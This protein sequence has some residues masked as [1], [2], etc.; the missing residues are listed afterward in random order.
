MK[1]LIKIGLS[2]SRAVFILLGALYLA[3]YLQVSV[4][5]FLILTS[6]IQMLV[7]SGYTIGTLGL[8]GG[9][10]GAHFLVAGKYSYEMGNLETIG[11][12]R[13]FYLTTYLIQ[14][15]LVQLISCLVGLLCFQILYIFITSDSVSFSQLA[16]VHLKTI[17]TVLPLQVI[18]C[19][20]GLWYQSRSEPFLLI[21][22]RI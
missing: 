22:E 6:K 2:R 11:F 20:A 3:V 9:I 15:V 7:I 8:L 17:L 13:W 14:F 4:L 12:P 21:K 1:D 5:F 16:I 19:A 18:S 10:A